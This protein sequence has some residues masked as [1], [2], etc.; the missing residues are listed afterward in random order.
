MKTDVTKLLLT[1]TIFR[2]GKSNLNKFTRL[3]YESIK[4][5][6]GK[7]M[8]VTKYTFKK[9]IQ[10]MMNSFLPY[11]TESFFFIPCTT[12]VIPL[13]SNNVTHFNAVLPTTVVTDD[14]VLLNKT[15]ILGTLKTCVD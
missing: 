7:C 6:K 5:K 3:Y 10:S 14:P 4:K 12:L 2:Q 1:C 8:Q 15:K 13:S 9:Q 11:S